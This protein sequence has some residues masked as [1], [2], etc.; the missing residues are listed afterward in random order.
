MTGVTF[1]NCHRPQDGPENHPSM[2]P[3]DRE[4]TRLDNDYLI[5]IDSDEQ[6]IFL[7]RKA[8]LIIIWWYATK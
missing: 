7:N 2:A 4:T 3:G 8:A 5:L 6:F 1:I